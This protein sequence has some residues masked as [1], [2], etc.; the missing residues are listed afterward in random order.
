MTFHCSFTYNPT[1]AWVIPKTNPSGLLASPRWRF[2]GLSRDLG[3]NEKVEMTLS[4]R[5]GEG[6]MGLIYVFPLALLVAH[7][8]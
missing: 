1:D 2:Y 6:H 4:A 3:S 5:L 7:V 8:E